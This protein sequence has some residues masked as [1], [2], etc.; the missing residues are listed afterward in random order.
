MIELPLYSNYSSELASLDGNSLY[1]FT[2][3]DN[4]MLIIS[5]MS[6]RSSKVCKMNDINEARI[7]SDVWD[8][9]S[10]LVKT[11]EYLRE[12]CSLIC[13]SSDFKRGTLIQKGFNHPA[14]WAHYADDGNGVCL[15]LDKNELISLNKDKMASPLS[16][17]Y[18]VKYRYVSEPKVNPLNKKYTTASDFVQLFYKELFFKKN[19]DWK[20][21]TE[22]RV[23]FESPEVFLNIKGAIK[24][25]ILGAKSINDDSKLK[26]ISEEIKKY[27]SKSYDYLNGGSFA[28]SCASPFGYSI[29]DASYLLERWL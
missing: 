2:K 22:E 11:T 28:Y 15:V 25:I 14:M 5:S 23:V 1:H 21:E 3:F 6:L 24:Y 26:T 10:G 18:K 12:K 27:S 17:P 9:I 8:S 16:K 29:G 19:I 20:N 4:F 7:H 13:F